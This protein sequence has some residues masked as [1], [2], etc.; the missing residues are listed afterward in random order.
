MRDPRPSFR[1]DALCV[2]RTCSYFSSSWLIVGAVGAKA[3]WHEASPPH[4]MAS[5]WVIDGDSLRTASEEIRLVGIDAPAA[6]PAATGK[7]ANGRA[8]AKPRPGLQRSL[9]AKHNRRAVAPGR[10]TSNARKT[11]GGATRGPDRSLGGAVLGQLCNALSQ[12][13]FL[14]FA[15]SQA[16][17]QV[18]R[19]RHLVIVLA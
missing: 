13:G 6:I 12:S 4:F 14:S 19:N 15:R 9:S 18:Q 8:A 10:V 7:A 3:L 16:L 5:V 1:V 2:R 11:G 17:C